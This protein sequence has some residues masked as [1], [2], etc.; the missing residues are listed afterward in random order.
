M[1]DIYLEIYSFTKVEF[2]KFFYLTHTNE[3]GKEQKGWKERVEKL[4]K[5]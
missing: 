1:T 3:R 5:K 2:K 4:E